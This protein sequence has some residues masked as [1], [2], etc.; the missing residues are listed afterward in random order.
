VPIDSSLEKESLDNCRVVLVRPHFAG[1]VGAI[2]RVMR[3][4]GASELVLVEPVADPLS[5][6]ARQRSTHGESILEAARVVTDLPEAL[7]GCVAAAATSARSGELIR[8]HA[9][10]PQACARSLAPLIVQARVALVFGPEPSGLTNEE[11]TLCQHLVCIP[12]DPVYPALNLAQSVGICLYE[13]RMA[14]L[15]P[16]H[17]E[18]LSTPAEFSLQQRMFEA[19]EKSLVEIHYLFGEKGPILMHALR[20]LIGRAKPTEM[21]VKLLFGLARQMNWIAKR[22]AQPEP[23][24]ESSAQPNEMSQKGAPTRV[25]DSRSDR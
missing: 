21:E 1:N 15:A 25:D 23:P 17:A 16:T 22:A 6:A 5:R 2:A 20:H 8:S 9:T 13:L 24:T 3:N 4:L 12:T 10:D 14:C 19:L 11:I 18:E 7:A